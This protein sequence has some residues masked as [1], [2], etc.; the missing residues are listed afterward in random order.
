MSRK[1]KRSQIVN[2]LADLVSAGKYE[3]TGHGARQMNELFVEVAQL[4]NELEAEE[5]AEAAEE[6]N[7]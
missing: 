4:I 6:T 7:E 1:L 2:A 3:L 5:A